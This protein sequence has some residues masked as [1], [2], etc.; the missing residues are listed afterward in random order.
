M[1]RVISRHPLTLDKEPQTVGI[2]RRAKILYVASGARGP[3]L[4]TECEHDDVTRAVDVKHSRQFVVL[5][6]GDTAPAGSCYI[7]SCGTT[8]GACHVYE[9]PGVKP[10]GL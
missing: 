7:G 10:T 8:R 1:S 6:P 9:L 3:E 4:H 2:Q 5:A